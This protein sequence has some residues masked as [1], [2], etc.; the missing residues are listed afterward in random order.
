[1]GER[2]S[3]SNPGWLVDGDLVVSAAQVLRERVS[4]S[5]Y[6]KP[7][8]GLYPAQR[9]PTRCRPNRGVEQQRRIPLHPPVLRDVFHLD[10]AL[11]QQLLHVAVGQAGPQVPAHCSTITSAGNRR[12]PANAEREGAGGRVGRIQLR[13]GILPNRHLIRQCNPPR[14]ARNCGHQKTCSQK[15]DPFTWRT[16]GGRAEG[17]FLSSMKRMSQAVEV[18]LLVD[19]ILDDDPDAQIIVAGDF[20]ATPDEVPVLVIRG[21]VEDTGSPNHA[22][23]VLVSI[24]YTVPEPARYTLFHQGK[25]QMLDHMLITR[26]L[27]A[28]YHGSEIHSEILHDESTAFAT[29]VKYPESD[30]APVVATFDFT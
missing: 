7:R 19:Q 22:A 6:P 23:R 28:A 21:T 18:R 5:E 11:G 4:R 3:E 2:R 1:L 9:S 27:L 15:I 14:G 17:S 8:H 24:E 16:P 25:V 30:H 13:G 20:N 29:D 26:N 10:A 12:K